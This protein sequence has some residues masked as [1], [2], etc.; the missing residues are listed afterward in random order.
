MNI[1]QMLVMFAVIPLVIG[2]L[3]VTMFTVEYSVN[4]FK[5]DIRSELKLAA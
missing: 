3:V 1:K 2:L 4:T 5:D